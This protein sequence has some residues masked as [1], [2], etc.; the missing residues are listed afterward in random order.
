MSRQAAPS[1]RDDYARPYRLAGSTLRGRLVRLGPA[2]DAMLSRHAYPDTV[3]HAVGEAAA[4]S[5]A[6]AQSLD[7][8]GIFTLQI[9]GDGPIGTLVADVDSSGL[10]RGYAG[11]DAARLPGPD[12]GAT[13]PFGNGHLAFTV[14]RTDAGERYQGIVGLDGEGL[15]DCALRYFGRSEQIP[16]RLALACGR[17]DGAWRAGAL[18]LQ[19]MPDLP[20]T[21]APSETAE[22]WERLGRY[23]GT[24][25]AGEL[26]DPM[27]PADAFL[28]RLFHADGLRVD[29]G[30][31]LREGCRCGGRVRMEMV[32]GS[33]SAATLEEMRRPDGTLD[34]T[35]R[36]C[37]RSEL[38]TREDIAAITHHG[39]RRPTGMC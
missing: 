29:P 38:F 33:M 36:F 22:L 11:F 27:L 28:I 32:L 30:S 17:R 15:A 6:L 37:S 26:L 25:G 3:S 31:P 10:M 7:F 14:D 13:A 8:N 4:L 5:A 35:C 1:F 39:D 20:E 16:T 2:L 9:S 12:E 21:A 18:L 23:F 24:I 19:R 34:M